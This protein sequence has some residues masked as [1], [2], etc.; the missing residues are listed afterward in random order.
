MWKKSVPYPFYSNHGERVSRSALN[1]INVH[2]SFSLSAVIV[3]NNE[4][5]R[6]TKS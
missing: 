3:R 4:V 1:Y 6:P 5:R 2:S